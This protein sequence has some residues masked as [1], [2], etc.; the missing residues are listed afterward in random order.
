MRNGFRVVDID[1]HVNP[2]YETRVKYLDPDARSR[3]AEFDLE[4]S[5]RLRATTA[6]GQQCGEIPAY[7]LAHP[8]GNSPF[9]PPGQHGS[10][11]R[12]SSS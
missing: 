3:V 8:V 6:H 10:A 11:W 9:E 7:G 5:R 2:S 1:T 4:G 12:V